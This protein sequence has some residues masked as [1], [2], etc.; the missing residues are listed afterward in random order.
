MRPP[1]SP[2]QHLPRQEI[3]GVCI[4]LKY[5]KIFIHEDGLRGK[6]DQEQG[7]P[8]VLSDGNRTEYYINII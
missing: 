4:I 2:P 3:I 7:Y 8:C 5:F 1:R 6:I